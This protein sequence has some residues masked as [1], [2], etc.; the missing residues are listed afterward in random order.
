[1]N[2][3]APL[4]FAFSALSIPI[5]LLYML[6]LRRTEV[7][8][9]S[10]FL[11]QQLVRDR[12]ANA[13]WQKLRFSWL[14]LLQLLILAAL[15]IAL[16]RPFIEV[17]TISAG[18]IVLLLDASA[19]M[20][21]T[22]SDG[23]RFERGKD[24][25]RDLIGT[26]GGDDN[27]TII[28]VSD[29][30]EVLAS[31]SEDQSLLRNAIDSAQPGRAAAD[32][33][34]ALTLAAAGARGAETLDVVIVSDG[35]LPNNLP[36]IP[37][38][39]RLATVGESSE[40]LAITALATR[41]IPGER[42]QL[43]AQITN[44][45]EQDADVIFSITLDGDL[46][47][48]QRYAVSAGNRVDVVEDDLPAAFGTLVAGLNT[49][50]ASTVPDYLPSDDEAYTVHQATGAGRVLLVTQRNI[51]LSQIFSSLPGVE[52]SSTS[53]DAGLPTGEFDLYVLDG[54]LPD[55]LPPNDLFIINPPQ[56]NEL[57]TV[58]GQI[59]D[60]NLSAA[61]DVLA[62]DPRTQF[63]DFDD[64][65]IRAFMQISGYEEWA[66]VLVEGAGGP[67]L[68]AGE[69]GERQ[70]AVLAF[71]LQDSDLPLQ[72]AWPILVANLT[73]WYTPPRVLNVQGNVEPGTVVVMRPILG[74]SLLVTA[75]D[76]EETTLNLTE[77]AQTIYAN[78][79]QP[80]IYTVNIREDGTVIGTE[81][82]AVNLF[83]AGES[84]IT[85]REEVTIGTSTIT[86]SAREEVGQRELWPWLAA[87]GLLILL[88]EWLYYHRGGVQKM[89]NRKSPTWNR[90]R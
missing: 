85:P 36:E 69:S 13:P 40:N 27:M 1:M 73:Q 68:I 80:G 30:P 15:V 3:L 35:G 76:G 84:D 25:A 59:E 81:A 62:D 11:W 7:Q 88:I 47:S 37:G 77:S 9:S 10:N 90:A 19:S 14:L 32:W 2:F 26:L 12:E 41:D 16:A 87:L 49:P 70:V 46:F 58:G 75:P 24:I 78:T 57:F 21:A 17:E 29:V 60:I 20:N 44:Y 72:L 51:F 8:I 64:V 83:D 52:L 23:T 38:D 48:A 18:R 4:A 66:D 28:R 31:S 74:D 43:F 50:A 53:P 55:E 82:F 71:A 45:G 56:S 34:A 22:D 67:L 39:I 54:W 79:S 86:E 65:N 33:H 61:T 89:F 5:F 42:P 6:R 63:L